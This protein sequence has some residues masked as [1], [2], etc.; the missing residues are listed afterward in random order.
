[1]EYLAT[2]T[3]QLSKILRARRGSLD[4]TQLEV[5]DLVGLLPKT[6]SALENRAESSS[7]ETLF[8]CLSALDLEMRLLPKEMP[9]EAA[10]KP[11][12]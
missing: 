6:V 1:M 7:I 10:E 12:W 5:A 2:T 11:E 8:K 3:S 4:L 9:E